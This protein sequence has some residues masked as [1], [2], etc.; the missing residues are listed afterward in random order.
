MSDAGARLAA[1]LDEIA[2]RDVLDIGCGGGGLARDLAARGHVVAGIDPA[3]Q[4]VAAAEQLVPEARFVIGGA[5]AL[6]FADA[7]F[8]AAIFLNSLH[9]VPVAQMPTALREALRVL[10]PGGEV[11]IVEPLAQGAFSR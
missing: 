4:A 10:R 9:H 8:D 6:P 2:A 11:V 7:S 3:P 5:E 1:I